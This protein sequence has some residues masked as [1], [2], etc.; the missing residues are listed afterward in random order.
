MSVFHNNILGGAAGQ[1]GGGAVATD[2]YQIDRSL[3]FESDD[4]AK[5]TRT[6]ST[7]GNRKTWTWSAWIKRGKK[8]SNQEYLFSAQGSGQFFILGFLG[9][10]EFFITPNAG[11]GG[12]TFKSSAKFRDYSAWYHFVVAMDTTQSTASDRVKV[13]VNGDQITDW[14]T[15]TY[16]SQDYEWHVN[17]NVA[18][19]IGVST[20]STGY[21]NVYMAEIHHVDGQQLAASD[22]GEYDDNNV[23]QPKEFTGSYKSF[24]NSQTWS[25]NITTTGNSGTF[26]SS[27]PATN[28]FNNND[29]NYAHGN[30]DG[31]QTA[32]VTLTLSPGVSCSNTVSF[33]GGMT[34]SGTATISVNGGTAVNLTS[35]SSATTKTDVSF[36]GTVTSIVITKTSSD[37]SGMLI[38]GFEIDGKRLVDN[39]VSISSNSF[40][41]KFADNS[42]NA[43]LGTDSSGNSN[44]WTVNNLVAVVDEISASS[45]EISN[46]NNSVANYLNIFDGDTS[47]TV[48]SGNGGRVIWTPSSNI[49]ISKIEG[50]F[51][52]SLNGYRI[53]MSVSGGSSQTITIDTSSGGTANQWNEFTSLSGDTIGPSNA[54]TFSMLR[55]AGNDTDPGL[56]DLNA[57]RINDKLVVLNSSQAGVD[58]LIDTPTNYTADSGN[59]GGNY[60]TMNPLDMKSNV[61]TQNGNMEVSNATAGWSGIRGTFGVSS[62]KWYYELTTETA[63]IFAGIATAGVDIYANAPQDSTSVMDDG[64][65]VY[66]DDG[67]YLLDQGGSANRQTYG[68]ALANGDILGV[69][70]DLDGNTVQF[71]KNGSALGSIDISS[72]PLASN[73]VFPYYISYYSSTSTFFNFG[74]RPF[75][76]TPP[77]GHKS[78]CTQ[79]FDDPTIADGS[80]VLDIVNETTSVA[81]SAK[82]ISGLSFSPDLVISK[83]RNQSSNGRWGFIDIVRGVNKTLASDR[84]DVEVTSQSDLLTQFNS[85]GF[86]VGADAAGYGW[87]YQNGGSLYTYWAWDAGTSTVSNTD[88]SITSNVRANTSAGFSIVGY[89]GTGTAATIGHGLNAA[90]EFIIVKNRDTAR[91]WSVFHQSITNMSSGYLNLNLANAFTGSYTGVWNATDPT[92]SVFS[93]GT[94]NESNNSGDDFIAYCWTPVAGYSSFGSYVGNGSSNGPFVFLGFRPRFLLY[95]RTDAADTVGWILTDSER[96]TYNVI[97][98][99]LSPTTASAE[100]TTDIVDFLSNGFKMR[101]AGADG[102]I[103]NG[104]YVYAAFAEHPLKTARAR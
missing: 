75:A 66:C 42:S 96:N 79:N 3:R 71:Y 2:P 93:V 5:L 1:T 88:G 16:P 32:V 47:T 76:Y 13:Y 26:H 50:Y 4:S 35:G 20:Q 15:A 59:N 28:A 58:S 97:D 83:L 101:I 34:G 11:V 36:S 49:S 29:A 43:A 60:C 70:F 39:G 51:D 85:D 78:L 52:D 18:H 73:T 48:S 82:V 7:A 17:N 68:S 77:T 53:T 103:N 98:D 90:P 9:D 95:K 99:Y 33:L 44:T 45:S 65:L 24:D 30:G 89:T 6:F 57:L 56:H 92:S 86:N 67:K 10:D 74:Q 69:A 87:N 25:S 12:P 91:P 23:W 31:S 81:G 41:L 21:C 102:N 19:S 37:N 100:G 22:F 72:S 46:P 54:I 38:Y 27:Y 55:P 8:T 84:A 14:A 40:Y 61:A 80:T 64:A 104:T 94:D 62:G 63:S